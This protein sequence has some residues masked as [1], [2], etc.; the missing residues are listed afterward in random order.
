MNPLRNENPLSADTL[1]GIF[2]T[3]PKDP[4]RI[5]N[6]EGISIEF[7]ESYNHGG[8]A[9][10]FKTM[11]SFANN[12]G[13]YII[14]GVGDRPRRLLGLR[15]RDLKQF[16]ELNVEILTKNLLD[17]GNNYSKVE[18][19]ILEVIPLAGNN[20]KNV[21]GLVLNAFTERFIL[22]R[23]FFDVVETWNS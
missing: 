2:R 9:Q 23:D 17:Y 1:T 21:K 15:E 22:P 18:K 11:A 5:I 19:H 3:S 12:S 20:D 14:Y 16:E 7:K 10:Y 4:K 8:M 13:G 6:R